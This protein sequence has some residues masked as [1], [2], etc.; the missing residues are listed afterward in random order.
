MKDL[1]DETWVGGGP[2]SDW[3]QPVRAAC[4]VAGFEPRA[5]VVS[6]DYLAVQAFVSAGVGIAMVPGLAAARSVASSEHRCEVS[7]PPETLRVAHVHDPFVPRA[8]TALV[9]LLPAVAARWAPKPS[10]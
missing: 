4:R 1:A 7:C 10:P 5:G 9:D 8:V 6:D 2:E 3:F